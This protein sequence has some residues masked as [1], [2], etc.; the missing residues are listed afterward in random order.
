MQS[1]S[2]VS[3]SNPK[4]LAVFRRIRNSTTSL[5]NRQRCEFYSDWIN[6]NSQD[7]RHLFRKAQTLLGMKHQNP[8]P[9]HSNPAELSKDLAN[10]FSMKVNTIRSSIESATTNSE[11]SSSVSISDSETSS[12]SI[13]LSHFCDVSI[14]GIKHLVSSAPNK[15]CDLDPIPTSLIKSSIHL[16][17][18]ILKDIIGTSLTS[19]HFP[20]QWKHAVIRPKLKKQNLDPLLSNYRPLSNLTFLSK[21]AEKAVAS[22]IIEH[23]NQHQL[24]PTTQSAYRKHHSTETALLKV[25]NDI[26]LNMNK[27]HIT[28]L[29]L[30]DLSSAFDTIDHTILLNRL[31]TDFGICDSSLSWVQSYLSGRTQSVSINSTNSSSFPVEFGVPQGSCLGPLL[32]TLYT[33]PLFELIKSHLPSMHCYADDTQIYLSFKPDSP[34]SEKSAIQAIESCVSEIRSWL[35]CNKLLINDSK[36]EFQIIGTKHQLSKIHLDNILVGNSSISSSMEVRNLGSWFDNN[37]SVSTHVS[38]VASS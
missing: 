25:K 29:V 12:S 37:L 17:A 27:Q 6:E 19:G 11:A 1:A 7:Q 3:T 28:F 22:Q 14:D 10:C 18:P 2:G 38:K 20:S 24:F 26:L 33:S 4:H 9:P 21:L 15:T 31:R 16:L 8:L 13:K 34:S 35:L 30:L 32:F 36:T 5:M 23:L